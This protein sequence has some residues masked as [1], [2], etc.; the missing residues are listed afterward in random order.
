MRILRTFGITVSAASIF[1]YYKMR[2]IV[3]ILLS[4]LAVRIQASDL[5]PPLADTLTD[6]WSITNH[7]MLFPHTTDEHM[8]FE[9][10]SFAEMKGHAVTVM[11]HLA[12][13]PEMKPDEF[14]FQFPIELYAIHGHQMFLVNGTSGLIWKQGVPKELLREEDAFKPHNDNAWAFLSVHIVNAPHKIALQQFLFPQFAPYVH[15][16]EI[17]SDWQEAVHNAV[18][19]AASDAWTKKITSGQ[20]ENETNDDD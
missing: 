6:K 8:S 20:S 13:Q 15:V 9:L 1:L 19:Q 2:T 18:L 7:M 10:P 17:F 14:P 4:L 5:L 12:K 11:N 3:I 16:I